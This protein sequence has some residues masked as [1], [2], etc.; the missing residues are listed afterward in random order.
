VSAHPVELAAGPDELP[1]VVECLAN[2]MGEL[3][4]IGKDHH[5]SQA[6]GGYAY[7][8][9]E[10]ITKSAAPL[11][12]KYG[13]VFVPQVLSCEIR[14]ITVN[15]KPW[16]D[17]I[18]TVRYRICGPGGDYLEATVVGIGRDNADKG[19]N[20]ALTQA[21]KYALIQ[22]L[23][24]ADAKDDNDGVHDVRD[25][26]LPPAEPMASKHDVDLFRACVE[27]L[28]DEQR[29]PFLQ[30]KEDQGFSWPWT[31]RALDAMEAELERIVGTEVPPEP[32]GSGTTSPSVPTESPDRPDEPGSE[33]GTADHPAAASSGGQVPDDLLAFSDEAF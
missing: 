15:G 9:I 28:P 6:Q 5:A 32:E 8:G 29:I 18:L 13:I 7:R 27:E 22:T 4:A 14:E 12:A 26:D 1:T 3:P 11:F 24:I 20:K 17:T 30:W 16:T 10:A 31:Q 19:A 33:P 21:F 25:A 23:C 2:V